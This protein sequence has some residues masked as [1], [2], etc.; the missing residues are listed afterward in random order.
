MTETIN[1]NGISKETTGHIADMELSKRV[2][3]GSTH[4]VDGVTKQTIGVVKR[5]AETK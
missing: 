3:L 2:P 5:L 4:V 1:V